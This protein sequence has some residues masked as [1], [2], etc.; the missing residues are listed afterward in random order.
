MNTRSTTAPV[1]AAGTNA[2]RRRGIARW[3]G[4]MI[5]ALLIFGAVLFLAAGQLNWTAGWA[6]LGLH[7]FTQTLSAIILIRR[8]GEML[9]ERSQV[10]T[11][12][13]GW[14]RILTPAIVIVG[15]LAV[16]VT[17]GLDARFGWSG[18]L[19]VGLWSAGIIVAFL[20]QMFVLWAMTSNP[21][22]A[23][24]VHIQADRGQTVISSG[25]YRLVRHPGYAGSLIYNLAVPLVLGSWWTV[26]PA[27][28]TAALIIARTRLEDRTLL[29]ELPGYRTYAAN[30]RYRLFPGVWSELISR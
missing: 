14:D 27:L 17:A 30:V 11:G 15:T 25:P 8:Q 7:A 3:V 9:A 16:L 6:Y 24:T 18:F 19:D 5:A 20:S 22:F 12:T 1:T 26:I 4:Q 2:D 21:F 28:L 29:D 23:L 10:R 13:K